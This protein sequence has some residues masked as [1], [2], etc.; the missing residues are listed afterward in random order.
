VPQEAAALTL[1]ALRKA[2]AH[3]ASLGS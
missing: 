2:S 3:P 1:I